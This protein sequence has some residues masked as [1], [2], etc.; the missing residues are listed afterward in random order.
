MQ[1]HVPL[2]TRCA[3]ET[4]VVVAH[5][6]C[7]PTNNSNIVLSTEW[8]LNWTLAQ[9]P[10]KC[11][12]FFGTEEESDKNR[13]FLLRMCLF[14]HGMFVL[15]AN[16]RCAGGSPGASSYLRLTCPIWSAMHAA[17]PC[18]PTGARIA[19]TEGFTSCTE[20]IPAVW[21]MTSR[22][23]DVF[24]KDAPRV[25]RSRQPPFAFTG[26][27]E[28]LL[29]LVCA[30]FFVVNLLW[31]AFSVWC[32]RSGSPDDIEFWPWRTGSGQTCLTASSAD[33]HL[34][35]RQFCSQKKHL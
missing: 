19:R 5:H 1:R 23:G 25:R 8:S 2:G 10:N 12:F 4:L 34:R 13:T 20:V 16:T 26:F 18:R 35:S 6:S 3:R 11:V 28:P 30:S 24:K 15:S 33:S 32:L 14:R 22:R 17:E 21:M 31:G 29:L 7:T 27:Y 9:T